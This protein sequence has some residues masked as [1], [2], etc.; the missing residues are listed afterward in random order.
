MLQITQQPN[1]IL[2]T[3]K[4]ALNSVAVQYMEQ[5]YERIAS[6]SGIQKPERAFT[7]E[8]YH[9]LRRLQDESPNNLTYHQEINKKIYR[10]IH[11][12]CSPETNGKRFA[13][14]IV[15]HLSQSDKDPLNQALIC[16]IKM[17]NSMTLANMVKDLK[18]L[19]Y[20]KAS[21][22]HFQNAVFIFTGNVTTANSYLQR[23]TTGPLLQCLCEEK[24]KFALPKQ[25]LKNKYVWDI[26]EINCDE[27]PS[28]KKTENK[29]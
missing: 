10:T 7:A 11:S 14:D 4:Q 3:L 8:L 20:Y 23:L 12:P 15:L 22:L 9:Q 25:K 13:P 27:L 2:K 17:E 24:I 21:V 1:E 5:N 29:K 28:I 6:G 18:K 16:E 26:F 19:F